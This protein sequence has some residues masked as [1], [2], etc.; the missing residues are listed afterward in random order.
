[1]TTVERGYEGTI[2]FRH[3]LDEF[4]KTEKDFN[5]ILKSECTSCPKKLE[6]YLLT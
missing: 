1:M 3:T 4:S 2:K 5:R 6:M